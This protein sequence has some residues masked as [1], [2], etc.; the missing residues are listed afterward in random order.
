M[1]ARNAVKH[2][3]LAKEV[4]IKGEDPGEFEF[5]RDQMLGELAPVGQ[6]ESVL[7]ERV[8]SLSWR[9]QRAERLQGVAFETLCE[10]EMANPLPKFMQSLL[11]PKGAD[12]SPGDSGRGDGDPI[13]G[14][15]VVKDFGYSRVLDRLLMYERRI[16]HSLYR[17]M[18]EL[19]KQRLVRELD[20]PTVGVAAEAVSVGRS[21]L[22]RASNSE[23]CRVGLVPPRPVAEE[24]SVGQAPPYNSPD[25]ETQSCETN[26]ICAG[27]NEGQVPC[28]TEVM[29]DLPQGEICETNPI[30]EGKGQAAWLYPVPS[31]GDRSGSDGEPSES[32]SEP[33]SVV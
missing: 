9:L 30:P 4:V 17:T 20:P 1:V 14:R 19:Q 11:R 29:N 7:A 6:V 18:G 22:V 13:L 31:R 3:L 8:V 2:G 24:E 12:G 27:S 15:V 28:G 16:E 5:Y 25:A 33:A 10:K 23:V 26:P 21:V 32:W